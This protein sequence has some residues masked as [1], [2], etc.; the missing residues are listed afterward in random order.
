MRTF[1]YL[2]ISVNIRMSFNVENNPVISLMRNK[3]RYCSCRSCSLF[4]SLSIG[5]STVPP[6]VQQ[7]GHCFDW[8]HCPLWSVCLHSEGL[9][10][11]PGRSNRTDRNRMQGSRLSSSD[12]PLVVR[13]AILHFYF[14]VWRFWNLSTT[15][16]IK[17]KG[18][19]ITATLADTFEKRPT[20]SAIVA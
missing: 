5:V 18:R 10:T 9:I 14:L 4:T 16:M 20:G 8:R 2:E 6:P 12:R 17:E 7:R 3:G 13:K 19:I 15:M 11:C 1:R